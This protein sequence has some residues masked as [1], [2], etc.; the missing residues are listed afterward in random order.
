MAL[1]ENGIVQEVQ[2][3]RASRRDTVG[4]IY[5]GKVRRVLPGMQAAFI[6]IGLKRT[7]FLHMSDV[8][9]QAWDNGENT[10]SI[11]DMLREEQEIVVQVT[12]D[13]IG[14]KGARLTTQISIPSR[15]LVY[16]PMH[17]NCGVSQRIED[18][19]ERERL[20]NI[21]QSQQAK[22]SIPGGF[23][24]RTS[25]EGV[26]EQDLIREMK[27]LHKIWK[28]IDENITTCA[29]G[30]I[31]HQ[32]LP[33][34]KRAIRD[35]LTSETERL[36]VDSQLT[37]AGCREFSNLYTPKLTE[38]IEYYSGS[39]PIF[40]LFSVDDEIQKALANKVYLK[41]GGYLIID[42]AEAMTTIDVN[43]GTFVGKKNLEETIF[44]TNLEAAQAI[45][46]QLRLR[47]IGGIIIID[48][49]DME[50]EEHKE[51]VLRSLKKSL[52]A[53]TVKTSVSQVSKLGLVEMT[54]KRTRES[55]EHIL[56]SECPTCGGRGNLKT[57]ETVCYEIF[58][59]IIRVARQFDAKEFIVLASQLVIEHMIDGESG[60][61]IELE[62][63]VGKPIRFQ[64]EVL[65]AQ[66]Q[67]D[68]VMV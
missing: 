55:L 9:D 24:L 10:V 22:H 49:I 44:R 52:Y 46:R 1:I 66:D 19:Q 12:K 31:L 14:T 7:A 36:R 56:C 57:V 26:R 13:P 54:R 38:R 58:R 25:A 23:I 65:Y 5:K 45:S 48:F 37:F 42:Q 8:R 15:L 33:L 63:F 53:D 21:A 68:V 34:S 50:Q 3:E 27:I 29:V 60:Y 67:Y 16:L 35:L 51:Q 32:D 62:E 2:I 61:L 39:R 6:D 28:R 64:D 43:T 17:K 59:E 4:N 18:E 40:D 30:G 41:S 47:N 11:S 20:Y